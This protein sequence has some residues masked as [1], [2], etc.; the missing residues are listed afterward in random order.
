MR[1]RSLRRAGLCANSHRPPF[2]A[3]LVNI[4][5]VPKEMMV[6]DATMITDSSMVPSLVPSL[7]LRREWRQAV[8]RQLGREWTPLTADRGLSVAPVPQTER[9][10][11]VTS[12]L[13]RRRGCLLLLVPPVLVARSS[14]EPVSK[15][16]QTRGF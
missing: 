16:H 12:A 13:P 2:S 14:F 1:T 8:K 3:H 10:D 5:T 11:H 15:K 9:A 4:A 7:T 6:A